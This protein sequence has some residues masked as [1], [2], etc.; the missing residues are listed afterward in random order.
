MQNLSLFVQSVSLLA[1]G[2][3]WVFA[4]IAAAA[5]ILGIEVACIWILIRKFMRAKIRLRQAEE[6]ENQRNYSQYAAVAFGMAAVSLTAETVL[7][8]LSILVAIGALLL[9]V[10]LVVFH[11]CGYDYVSAEFLREKQIRDNTDRAYEPE[12]IPENP[13]PAPETLELIEEQTE[14]AAVAEVFATV[15]DAPEEPVDPES[16]VATGE[17]LE[18]EPVAEDKPAA[19]QPLDGHMAPPQAIGVGANG[20]TR[21]VQIEKQYTETVKEVQTPAAT[22]AV[23]PATGLLIEKLNT[24]IDKMDQ[25]QQEAMASEHPAAQEDKPADELEPL[26]D[27]DREDDEDD[28]DADDASDG[29]GEDDRDDEPD[30]PEHFTGNERIIGF[31][32]ATGCYIVAH[33]RKS[34]EAKLTQSRPNIKNY[35][36][37]IK[38]ALLA[39]KGTKSRISWTADSF[40]NGR[41]A[42]AKI[43]AKT[44][45]LE[46]YLAL[47]PA[48]L[49]GTVYRGHDV[50]HLKKYAD[51]P[52]RYKI[53]TPR[54]FKW[55][56]ELVQR[57]CEEHGLSPIDLERVDYE[58]QYPFEDTDSLVA[59]GLIKEYIREENPASTF[60]L[61]DTHATPLP[62]EDETVIPANANFSWEFDNEMLAQKEVEA[63]EPIVESEPEPIVETEPAPTVEAEPDPAPAPVAESVGTVVRETTKITQ[64]RYTEQYFGDPNSPTV[65]KEF[66]SSEDP[67]S[68]DIPSFGSVSASQDASAPAQETEQTAET[69]VNETETEI[70]EEEPLANTTEGSEEA[71]AAEETEETEVTDDTEVTK[72]EEESGLLSAFEQDDRTVDAEDDLDW[73]IPAG[74]TV[75]TE[76]SS[77]DEEI[78]ADAKADASVEVVEESTEQETDAEYVEEDSAYAENGEEYAEEGY[79]YDENGE[80]YT[81]EGYGYDENDGEYTEE[82]YAYAENGEEYAE[83]DYAYSEN[84]EEYAEEDYVYTENGEEYAE[85]SYAYDE[86]GEE[87]TEEGYVYDENGEEYAE[88]Y[89]EEQPVQ[90]QVN[91]EIALIDVSVLEENF[92]SGAEID[93]EV[94]KANG[95]VLPSAKILKISA[96]GSLSK[97]FTVIADQFSM[98]A[99]IAIDA[100]GGDA[101]KIIKR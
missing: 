81:E 72:T 60:E 65:Y 18:A 56:L 53:R 2:N 93:L 57:V 87:Y 26:D 7:T 5:C 47:D 42:I 85:E 101:Q 25:K 3:L 28:E 35:Y 36:S 45:I 20:P 70:L 43:N 14:D 51:T 13:V 48:S 9:L 33:Y 52:F 1:S 97:A 59:R 55:A 90:P 15:E 38:N 64:M 30:D 84:G 17:V 6:E 41:A 100:A 32:E 12:M 67:F 34:F 27:E 37:E 24:L 79:A 10:L 4:G 61:D 83:E 75:Q 88:D 71:D 21:I 68:A 86:N 78:P 74:L 95:L 96:T 40:H 62:S 29:K 50:G 39:Y 23:D 44:R 98:N 8:V 31:D 76:L 77:E 58:A 99:I 92:Q 69:D 91:P 16:E 73:G 22:P 46:L 80:E 11:F 54:K 63:A 49:E 94:L 82:G 89:V 19:E 66:L